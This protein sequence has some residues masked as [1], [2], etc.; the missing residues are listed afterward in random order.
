MSREYSGLTINLLAPAAR[1]AEQHQLERV[2][3][4]DPAFA[5]MTDLRE[6]AP[7]TIGPEKRI[8]EANAAMLERGVRLLF[9][10]DTTRAIVGVITATDL[11]GEKP[12]R[13]TQERGVRRGEILVADIMTPAAMLEA[14]SMQDV[15]QMRVGHI[16]ATLKAVNRQHL[17]ASE[18]NGRRVRGLFSASRIARQLGVEVVTS[19]VAKTFAQI[20]A[21]LAR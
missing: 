4:D 11:L 17:M 5:V 15:A 18:E 16:V 3:L 20:E 8:D 2:T 12:V 7:A 1:L 9:V 21:A 10:I 13:H 6:V 14:I 19:E